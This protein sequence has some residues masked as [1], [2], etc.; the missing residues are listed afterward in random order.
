M[1]E[2]PASLCTAKGQIVRTPRRFLVQNQKGHF[3]ICHLPFAILVAAFCSVIF[4]LSAVNPFGCKP[5]TLPGGTISQQAC[6]NGNMTHEQLVA[7]ALEL[8]PAADVDI[9]KLQNGRIVEAAVV[10]FDSC[11]DTNAVEVTLDR[12]SGEC[13][14]A[15]IADESVLK[16]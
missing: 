12:S 13:L 2:I 7:K 15:T 8:L 4:A 6:Q 9:T 1:V 11:S 5:S 16:K 14:G 10:Y 3:A